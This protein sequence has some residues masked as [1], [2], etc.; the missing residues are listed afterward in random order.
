M[1]YGGG[2]YLTGPMGYAGIP[3]SQLSNTLLVDGQGQANQG[4]GHDAF[5]DYPYARLDSIR[6]T[7]VTLGRDRA[8]I[9]ADLGG[10]YR[11]ELGI[12]RLE[13]R[14]S[15]AH[16]AWTTTDRMRASK[17]VVLTAQVHADQAIEQVAQR[18]FVIAGKP[19]SLKVDV[20]TLGAKAVI[21]PGV[22]TAAGPPGNVDK[23]PTEQRGTVL[24]LSLPASRD[25]TL[26]TSMRF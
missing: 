14:F 12:E 15:F 18:S 26:V 13:R 8:D 1:L 25:A 20:K 24:R 4:H 23:G 9:V 19:S 17:P 3:T 10:A 16:G 2:S 21:E 7:S 22:V 11:P 5:K 6:I